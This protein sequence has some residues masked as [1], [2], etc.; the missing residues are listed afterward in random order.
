MCDE[1]VCVM[2]LR[3]PSSRIRSIIV[4]VI[5]AVAVVIVVVAAVA[6]TAHSIR[7]C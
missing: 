2:Y 3:K 7:G 1:M 6:T 5:V 4:V